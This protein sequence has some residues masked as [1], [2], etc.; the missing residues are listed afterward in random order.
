MLCSDSF[1]NHKSNG[2]NCNKCGRVDLETVSQHCLNAE[3]VVIKVIRL[4]RL[5]SLKHILEDTSLD[6][7][8]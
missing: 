8:V 5:E 6:I 3:I 4:C 1:C 7:K 2:F